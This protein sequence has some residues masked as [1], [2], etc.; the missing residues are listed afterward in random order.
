MVVDFANVL[1]TKSAILFHQ[2]TDGICLG[3]DARS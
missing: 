1:E 3:K 2:Y